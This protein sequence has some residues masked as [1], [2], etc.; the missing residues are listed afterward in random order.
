[1]KQR[2]TFKL[3]SLVIPLF[4]CTVLFSCSSS[5]KNLRP[6]DTGNDCV[7]KFKPTFAR[8]LYNTQVNILKHHLSGI[9]LI[10]QMPDSSI[11]ILFTMET[12]FKF[13][14]F[15]FNK[16]GD[17][18]VYSIIDKMNRKPVIKTLKKDFELALMINV[19][20][21]NANAFTRDGAIYHQ[22]KNE[23]LYDYYIT[24]SGCSKLLRIEHADDRKVKTTII[25]HDYV[26]GIPDTI[27][28][29][30]HNIKF[31]IGLKRLETIKQENSNEQQ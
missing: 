3:K 13:F 26:N 2:K 21:S 20:D 4:T 14:D 25:M 17:F 1:L 6:V 10:K 29:T 7:Q 11:R 19:I 9:L 18:K 28:I 24:D 30:H 31:N 23:D 15:E 27:G 8:A 22:F 5:Y 16:A 12:G